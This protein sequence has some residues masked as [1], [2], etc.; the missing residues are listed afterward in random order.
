MNQLTDI[1]NNVSN[2]RDVCRRYLRKL[3]KIPLKN[4]LYFL[5]YLHFW[6]YENFIIM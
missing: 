3:K 2:T 5:I 4:V 6:S 1:S